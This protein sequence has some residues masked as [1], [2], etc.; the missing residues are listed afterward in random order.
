MGGNFNF[1][2]E[3]ILRTTTKTSDMTDFDIYIY[4]SSGN[5][6]GDRFS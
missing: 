2:A 6:Y 3:K 5:K 4:E 1:K